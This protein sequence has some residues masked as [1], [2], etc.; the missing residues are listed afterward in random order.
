MIIWTSA[1]CCLTK[2]SSTSF[3]SSWTRCLSK[4]HPAHEYA[5]HVQLQQSEAEL[6]KPGA[7]VKL[8]CKTSGYT[9]IYEY[10][11]CVKQKPGQG[12]EWIG[13][14]FPNTGYIDLN[15]K[16]KGKAKLTADKSSS[17]AFMELRSLT[18]EDSAVYYCATHSVATTSRVYQ[19]PGRSRKLR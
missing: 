8:S 3:F 7:S 10:I 6:V 2:V 5:N 13:Y 1:S 17:T 4:K 15:Q 9:F 18:S 16:F 11:H 12:L 14:F 19:K